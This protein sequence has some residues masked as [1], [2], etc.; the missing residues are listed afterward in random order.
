MDWHELTELMCTA[1]DAYAF[2]R[3]NPCGWT[4]SLKSIIGYHRVRAHGEKV[5]RILSA[6]PRIVHSGHSAARE[7]A[8]ELAEHLIRRYPR[9]YSTT[10][11]DPSTT[12]EDGWYG[13][14]QM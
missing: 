6:Q 3:A 12:A 4:R 8:H 11:H 5:V 10:R 2:T 1:V 14:G 9:W 13:E 7:V